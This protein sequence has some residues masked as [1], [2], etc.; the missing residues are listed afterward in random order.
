[1]DGRNGMYPRSEDPFIFPGHSNRRP[2]WVT[3]SIKSGSLQ[4]EIEIWKYFSFLEFWRSS[5]S[6]T[7]SQVLLYEG[8]P[9]YM[10]NRQDLRETSFL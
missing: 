4:S 9:Q 1:M 2:G 8:Y 5:V 3:S 6:G 7:L 10:D